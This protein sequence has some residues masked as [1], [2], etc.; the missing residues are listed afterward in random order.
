MAIV[1]HGT[2]DVSVCNVIVSEADMHEWA[3]IQ[4]EL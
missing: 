1:S 4:A 2:Q 3:G